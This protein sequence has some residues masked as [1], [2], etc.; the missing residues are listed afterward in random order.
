MDYDALLYKIAKYASIAA[1]LV[2]VFNEEWAK[3]TAF[4][5]MT[6]VWL[7]DHHLDT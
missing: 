3:T 7:F 6:L 5:V 2:S 1:M 4:G